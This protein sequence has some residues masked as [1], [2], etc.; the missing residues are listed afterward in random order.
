MAATL[1]VSECSEFH[2]MGEEHTGIKTVKEAMEIFNSIPPDRMHGIPAIGVRVTNEESPEMFSEIDIFNGRRFDME[3]LSYVPEIGKD[4]NAQKL[5]AELIHV[6]PE[7]EIIGD[8][9]DGIQK[10]IQQ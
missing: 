2:S 8:I 6:N 9:P 1:T 10:K 7:A 5:I 3:A 4:W